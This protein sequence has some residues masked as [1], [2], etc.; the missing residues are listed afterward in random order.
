MLATSCS[1]MK[2]S[3]LLSARTLELTSDYRF[4]KVLLTEMLEVL[5]VM[6][7]RDAR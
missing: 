2:V 6:S 5:I 7:A 4:K 1:F 3:I